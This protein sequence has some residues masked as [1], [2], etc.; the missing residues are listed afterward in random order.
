MKIN[1]HKIQSAYF[2]HEAFTV[3]TAACYIKGSL[4][5]VHYL[6]LTVNND[7]GLNVIP[8]AI[9]SNQALHEENIT[10][11]CNDQL[12]DFDKNIKPEIRKL[13]FWSDRCCGQFRSQFVFHLMC[14]FPLDLEI[15]WNY[16]EAHHFKGPHD[17]IGGAVKRNIFSDVK[18][19][20][21]VIQNACHCIVNVCNVLYAMYCIA[22][23]IVL[24]CICMQCIV[25]SM[26]AVSMYYTLIRM[27]SKISILMTV[28]MCMGL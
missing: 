4:S 8:V 25:L 10:F 17:V 26:F 22:I 27:T 18:A 5:V 3:F 7:T 12:I 13:H 21:V 11:C 14:Y 6:N 23:Y 1:R 2:G 15:T 16:S 9:I 28:F 20:K 19:S 24:Q